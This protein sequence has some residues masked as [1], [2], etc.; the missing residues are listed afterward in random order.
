[1]PEAI[2]HTKTDNVYEIDLV[3][4]FVKIWNNRGIIYKSIALSLIIGVVIIIGSP[5]EFK[6]EVV[7]LVESSSSS[8]MNSMLQQLGGLAGLSGLGQVSQKDAL[9]PEL[10]PAIIKSTPFLLELLDVRLTASK[11]DSVLLVSQHLDRHCRKS[12]G[13]LIMENTI[14]L[15]R[16]FLR[17]LKGKPKVKLNKSDVGQNNLPMKLTPAQNRITGELSKRI[18]AKEG[19]ST[20]TLIITAEMQD[21]RLA[22]E[23]A[24]SVVKSLTGY[25]IDYRTQKAKADLKFIERNLI[26]AEKKYNDAQRALAAFQDRNLN[27]ITSSGRILEQNLQSEYTLAFNVYNTLAQ[28][29][30]Q[31]KIKVQETTPVFKVVEPAKVPLSKSRP[32]A[33]IIIL[34]LVVLGGFVGVLIVIA[35]LVFRKLKTK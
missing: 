7:L 33:T 19:E 27:I 2:K 13:K 6:S 32:R 35:R 10:Y 16:K 34:T 26:D 1:M 20:S 24:D 14:G 15:P 29:L 5:K 31:A 12:M 30:E 28:Q 23:L 9:T 25:I 11:Y 8:G 4:L 22:A 3:D 18:T 17:V 21:P